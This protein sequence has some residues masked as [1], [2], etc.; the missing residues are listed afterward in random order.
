M[1]PASPNLDH[2][3][4]H[5]T[6][7]G[8]VKTPCQLAPFRIR[9]AITHRRFL[10]FVL[11]R[12]WSQRWG[13]RKTPAGRAN[14][15]QGLATLEAAST[16]MTED[17]SRLRAGGNWQFTVHTV[18]L[19]R[20]ITL[21]S[22]LTFAPPTEA[23]RALRSRGRCPLQCWLQ[24][25]ISTVTTT[26]PVQGEARRHIDTEYGGGRRSGHIWG[27]GCECGSSLTRRWATSSLDQSPS[28][29][30]TNPADKRRPSAW[31]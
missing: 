24:I 19:A 16:M 11:G 21:K 8:P 27:L 10:R 18:I 1:S 2:Y 12:F 20:C 30:L 29:S 22:L 3:V 31:Q 4:P 13:R 6:W 7:L 28:E 17:R 9:S 26:R 25:P 15:R 14:F 5:L 23:T